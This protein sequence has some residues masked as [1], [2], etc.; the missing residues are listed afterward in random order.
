MSVWN[1]DI[2]RTYAEY[3][4]TLAVRTCNYCTRNLLSDETEKY[5]EEYGTVCTECEDIIREEE[6]TWRR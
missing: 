5:H 1:R 3:N 4:G 2:S 6:R